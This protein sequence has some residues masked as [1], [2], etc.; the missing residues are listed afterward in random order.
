MT[1]R[2][3]SITFVTLTSHSYWLGFAALVESIRINSGLQLNS[4]QFLAYSSEPIPEFVL[5]WAE[6]RKE[7]IR[8]VVGEE[9]NE[10][11]ALAS[12][13][14]DRLH[15]SFKKI[16]LFG[17]KPQGTGLHVFIDSDIICLNPLTDIFDYPAFAGAGYKS[18]HGS[19]KPWPNHPE[20]D[21]INGGFFIFEPSQEDC[22][23]LIELYQSNPAKY[24]LFAD[25][26]LLADWVSR[27]KPV[28]PM[29]QEWNCLKGIVI[30]TTRKLNRTLLSNVKLLHFTGTN[31]WD[32]PFNLPLSEGRFLKIERIWWR[33][34]KLAKLHP[35]HFKWS[36]I[37]PCYPY[38]RWLTGWKNYIIKRLCRAFGQ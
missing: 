6:E 37:G 28:T 24:S 18:D 9:L 1:T 20:Y 23:Q 11:T 16:A 3:K 12:Q 5:N 34:F 14:L 15:E 38:L 21:H 8:F 27:G 25:Q 10:W 13:Q 36:L 4:Y 31:P 17:I 30:P 29:P 26:D 19:Y 2:P 35:P 33:Y 22:R 32:L 7:A